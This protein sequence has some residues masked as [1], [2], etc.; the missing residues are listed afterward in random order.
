MQW[1]SFT[2]MTN[3]ANKKIKLTDSPCIRNCCLD[4]KDICQG[5]FRHIDEIIAWRSYTDK[6]KQSISELCQQRKDKKLNN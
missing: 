4:E 3:D 2:V 5:C 1:R 6:E